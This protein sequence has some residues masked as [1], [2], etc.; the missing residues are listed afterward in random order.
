MIKLNEKYNSEDF[1]VFIND[2]LPDYRVEEKD[3]SR[4]AEKCKIITSAR[5]LGHSQDL[6]VY[7]LEITHARNSDPRVTLTAEAFKLLAIYGIDKALVV[8]KSENS[9]NWRLSYMTITLDI[10]EKS[11]ITKS[12]SNPRRY[13]FYLGPNAKVRTPEKQL[14]EKG[15]IKDDG[16]LLG[17]FSIEVVNKEFYKEIQKFFDLLVGG[18]SL[19][20]PSQTNNSPEMKDFAVRLIGRIMF[21][22]FL[23]QKRGDK[24]SL[25]PDEL[26]SGFAVIKNKNYYHG[27][28]EPLFFELLNTSK[29]DRNIS[30]RNDLFDL[31]P[32]LNGGLFNP[33]AGDFYDFDQLSYS[34]RYINTLAIKDEWFVEFFKLLETYNFT[35]DENTVIDQELSVDPEMLGII[36]ENLL[37]EID[38][39]TGESSRKKTGSFYTPRPIVEY[40]VDKSLG[41]YL[42]DKTGME[43]KKI[44]AL[45]SYNLD[46]DKQFIYSDDERVAVVRAINNLRVI[47]PACGSGAFPIGMLQKVL[48]VLRCVDEDCEIWFAEKLKDVPDMIREKIREN[49]QAKSFD[50]TRKLSIIK[51]SIFG[52]DI[53]HI[54][55]EVSRLR[56]FLT[57]IVES[58]IDDAKTN[59]NIDPLPNLDFKFVC[60]NTLIPAPEGNIGLFGDANDTFQR[61]FEQEVEKYFTSSGQKK[62]DAMNKIHRLIDQKIKEK[63]SHITN[64]SSGLGGDKYKEA[65]VKKNKKKIDNQ[66]N[67][68]ALWE[69]YKNIFENKPV[70]FF[71][72][73]YFFPNVKNGFDICIGNPPY[74]ETIKDNKIL[75]KE[76]Y[77][78][79]EGKF[80]IY[81]YFIERGA[82]ILKD[83]GILTY[84]T[85]N[86][87]LT[88]G[89]FKKL[90][91][92]IFEKYYL[93]KIS[94]VLYNIFQSATV[95][96]NI[97][98][99]KKEKSKKHDYHVI[100]SDLKSEKIKTFVADDDFII[101]VKDNDRIVGVIEKDTVLL[102]T[103][104]EI[105]QGLI[106]Y[107]SKNQTR[108]FTSNTKD[109]EYHRKLLYGGDVGKYNIGWSGEYLKFGKWLHRPRPSYIYDNPKLLVQRI[110]N[111]QLNT[112]LVV[113]L[114]NAGYINGTGLSNILLL[115]GKNFDMKFLLAILNSSTI[116]YWFKFY[117]KDVNIKPEQL[118]KIPIKNTELQKQ[119]DI[120]KIV[121]RILAI[122]SS[123]NYNPKNPPAEQKELEKEIDKMVYKLYG[124][125]DEETKTVEN[126][127]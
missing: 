79:T 61:E 60:A 55:V 126:Y 16:D 87:W 58:E 124:L 47:D 50:Y 49:Y 42:I 75:F 94:D 74:G 113:A 70:D 51:D 65:I 98:F 105:W 119:K 34:S 41:Q 30:F 23:K 102:G 89:Y 114:D 106:A 84:I 27:V 127:E 25:I 95:D 8:F 85:P 6:D 66:I 9:D 33:Q 7:V 53:Q 110:R 96:T 45:I 73:K 64:F 40:M 37:G 62:S 35:I 71:E 122:T 117:F 80:E 91:K 99:I 10:D 86:T 19:Q 24:G 21:C 109:T 63:I 31:V 115:P 36:F 13:S 90:R 20:L 97:F 14:I 77:L 12:F 1:S 54:A 116:N 29:D 2:F 108:E 88:L 111:P 15:V 121:D 112:R 59:R 17:R 81:K 107:G 82:D 125:S 92:L 69:S 104:S 78:C 11:K 68:M 26:L 48:H 56:C 38:T 67:E 118:R 52:V 46:D 18:G 123:E 4:E 5:E 93:Y 44:E 72:I 28:L 32:Y 100:S 57:L 103:I 22:W 101:P 120:V 83:G 3:L 39:D 76:K 43:E